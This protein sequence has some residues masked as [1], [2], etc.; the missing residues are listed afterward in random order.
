[1]TNGDKS[2]VHPPL[3]RQ[4]H[5]MP[6][7][8][9]RLPRSRCALY[10]DALNPWNCTA[11]F[12][13]CVRPRKRRTPTNADGTRWARPRDGQ[14]LAIRCSTCCSTRNY[15][16]WHA[17]VVSGD[18]RVTHSIVSR[19]PCREM[20]C[21]VER[22]KDSRHFVKEEGDALANRE[23]TTGLRFVLHRHHPH[24]DWCHYCLFR[25]YRTRI[26]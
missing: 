12:R 18:V 6:Y 2:Q 16:D 22:R 7:A 15:S 1:M 17:L 4:I 20:T 8:L 13:V 3:H 26:T 11:L 9:R 25:E 24:R 10:K 5:S 23:T 19:V 21:S 14:C